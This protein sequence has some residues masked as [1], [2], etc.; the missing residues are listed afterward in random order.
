MDSEEILR[1]SI[2]LHPLEHDKADYYL[3]LAYILSLQD[4]SQKEANKNN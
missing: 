3:W 1:K 4:N 2:A